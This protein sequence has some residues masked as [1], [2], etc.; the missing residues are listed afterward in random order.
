[1]ATKVDTPIDPRRITMFKLDSNRDY[2]DFYLLG[3]DD[4]DTLVLHLKLKVLAVDITN[5]EYKGKSTTFLTLQ[6][7]PHEED[8]QKYKD[9]G[10]DL[11]RFHSDLKENK[12]TIHDEL[13]YD[14]ATIP[15]SLAGDPMRGSVTAELRNLWYMELREGD[16]YETWGVDL[17]TVFTMSLKLS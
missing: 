3:E 10:A 12:R 15:R 8:I 14:K 6:V 13:S 7:L 17:G 16:T 5:Y 9:A 1:M 2:E 11:Y 4:G